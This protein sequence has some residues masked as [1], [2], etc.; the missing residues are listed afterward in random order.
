MLATACTDALN[1]EWASE[2]ADDFALKT[3]RNWG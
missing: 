1:A 3:P 2:N